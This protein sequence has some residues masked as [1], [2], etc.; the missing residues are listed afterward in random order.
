MPTIDLSIAVY[1]GSPLDYQKY[2]HT[3]LCLQPDNRGTSMI[4]ILIVG[5]DMLYVI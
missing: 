5:P 2:R 3:A 1:V 4:I